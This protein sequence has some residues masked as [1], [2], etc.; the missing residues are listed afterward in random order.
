M[1]W[2]GR[3][4]LAGIAIFLSSPARAQTAS[5][6]IGLAPKP[7]V[8]EGWKQIPGPRLALV[9]P[10]A[11]RTRAPA[12]VKAAV[13]PA[14]R[15]RAALVAHARA[16]ADG[17]AKAARKDCSGFVTSVY[18]A[19]GKPLV[20]PETYRV[21]SSASAM[22][23]AWAKGEA[24]A[25]SKEAP[26]PG[27]LAFFRDTYGPR[28]GAITHV[29]MVEQVET[30]GTV[31]LVHYLSGRIKRDRMN[32]ATPTDP[33]TNGYFRKRTSPKEPVLAGELFVAFARPK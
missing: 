23:H 28:K 20:V 30:D 11:A 3:G 14:T 4:I 32:L 22:L 12:P 9:P 33:K 25:F 8:R 2:A 18:A 10:P 21:G 17:R 31:L 15:L 24:R 7:P 6:T 27:D 26:S 16:I 1:R 13:D 5:A 29:A 19:A